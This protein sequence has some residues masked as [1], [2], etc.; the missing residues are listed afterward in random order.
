MTDTPSNDLD[1]QA[2]RYIAAEMSPDEVTHFEQRLSDDQ[3]SREAVARAVELAEVLALVSADRAVDTG[4]LTAR[5]D[6]T[7]RS[8]WWTRMGWIGVG[9]AAALACVFLFR[10]IRGEPETNLAARDAAPRSTQTLYSDNADAT[11]LA[12]LWCRTRDELEPVDDEAWSPPSD[13]SKETTQA[14]TE[15]ES[16]TTNIG[17]G[18]DGHPGDRADPVEAAPSWMLAA[19]AGK[20]DGVDDGLP[21]PEDP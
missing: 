6:R 20:A 18:D 11:Q 4:Q 14:G 21:E 5:T 13:E 16:G 1:W 10:A 17:G 9:A 2:F 12:R 8:A 15:G 7:F 3:A 19:L